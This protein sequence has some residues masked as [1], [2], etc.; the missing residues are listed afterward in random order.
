[1]IPVLVDPADKDRPIQDEDNRL[2]KDGD[3]DP[4]HQGGEDDDE[5]VRVEVERLR[6]ESNQDPGNAEKKQAY[7]N[8]TGQLT[9][10]TCRRLGDDFVGEIQAFW[11]K[12]EEEERQREIYEEE[13]GRREIEGDPNNHDEGVASQDGTKEQ[14]KEAQGRWSI[15]SRRNSEGGN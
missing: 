10:G 13:Q 4:D 12:Q 1:M 3:W 2:R 8:Y 14:D 7:R 6:D 5:A 11:D 15:E 9:Y